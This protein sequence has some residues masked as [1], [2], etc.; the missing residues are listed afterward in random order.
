MVSETPL[1]IRV[2]GGQPEFDESW[3]YAWLRRRDHAVTYVGAT[4]LPAA[5]RTWLHLNSDDP[6]I[7]RVAARYRDSGLSPDEDH[8]V[9]AF[10][11]QAGVSRRLIK[12]NLIRM[13]SA[14][15][16]LAAD[17]VCDDPGEAAHDTVAAALADEIADAIG[18]RITELLP[19][20][21]GLRNGGRRPSSVVSTRIRQ[22]PEDDER[23][24]GRRVGDGLPP[25]K[26]PG[27]TSSPWECPARAR[28]LPAH[29]H[30]LPPP[31]G[32]RVL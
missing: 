11:V 27:A 2:H 18:R 30:A 17:H 6:E 14:R 12:D 7:G 8:E 16:G 10:P 25:P 31:G 29:R 23:A 4:G 13:L 24:P 32:P 3:V 22:R 15:G 28:N 19:W 9:V 5:L 20:G 1:S 21:F 26:Q